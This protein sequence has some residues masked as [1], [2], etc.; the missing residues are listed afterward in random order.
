MM[1]EKP[2]YLGNK[3]QNWKKK[4]TEFGFSQRND[5]KLEQSFLIIEPD[6]QLFLMEMATYIILIKSLN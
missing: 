4:Y 2:C 5:I 1:Q 6:V 3:C